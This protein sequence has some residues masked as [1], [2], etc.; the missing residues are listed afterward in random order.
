MTPEIADGYLLDPILNEIAMYLVCKK[1]F[2]E[3][4]DDESMQTWS[5]L[6]IGLTEKGLQ[7]WCVR[8]DCNVV[9]VNFEG[10]EHPIQSGW[11]KPHVIQ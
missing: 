3:L 11:A 7:A 8:H 4:P 2:D 9:H 1:C 10:H 5:R 6:N